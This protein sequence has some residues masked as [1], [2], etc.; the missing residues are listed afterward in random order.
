MAADRLRTYREKRDFTRTAEPS[1]S[2]RASTAA[3]R[4]YLIQKHAATRLHFDFRLEL[5][6]V[7]L[8]WAV[9]RGPSY[10]P[11]DKRLAVRTEDHPLEYGDFEGTIPKG[12]YGGGTVMLWDEG[13]WEPVGDPDAALDK[14]DF[15]FILHGERLKGKWVLVRMKPRPGERSKRENWLLI[16]ERDEYA[17][18]E[19]KP[20][21]ERAATSVRSGRTM[22]EIAEGNVEWLKTGRHVREGESKPAKKKGKPAKEDERPGFVEPQL[23]T[24]V[25]AAPLGDEWLHE[26]KYDGYRAL[27]AIGNKEAV[28]YTRRGLDWTD[29]FRPLARPLADLPCRSALVDGEVAITDAEGHTDFGALQDAM[30]D[31][32]RGIHY[33]L[34]DLLFLDGRD[35]RRLPLVER[36]EKLRELLADQPRAGPLFY[37]DHVTGHGD[38]FFQQASALGL[39]GIISKLADAPYRSGRSGTWLKSKTGMGQEFIIIGWRPSDV[40]GRPFSSLLLAVREGDHLRYAGRVGSG[41]GEPE[42]A[43]LWPELAKRRVKAPPVE[44]VPREIRRDA[45]FVK[46][47]L[48]AEIAYRG[49]TDDGIVRQASYKG[50][51]VDKKPAEVVVEIPKEVEDVAPTQSAGRRKPSAK[52]AKESSVIT[53]DKDD[54]HGTVTIQGVRITHPNRVLYPG[55]KVTKRSLVEYYVAVADRILPHVAG[56]PMSLVRCPEG[57]GGECFFQKHASPGFPDA[58][59]Q[60]QIR[61]KSGKQP[62]IYIEDAAGL[63][64]AVQMGVLELHIWGSHVGTLDQPDRIVF[65]F[66]PDEALQFDMVKDAAREMRERLD[67]LGLVSFVMASG[68][69]GLHVVV[70]LKPKHGWDD[71]KGFAEALART[72]A[73]ES[74]TRYLADMSKAKRKGRIFVDYLRNGRGATAIAPFST[75]A[76]KGAPVAWPLSWKALATLENAHPVSVGDA[77]AA[78]KRQRS[79]P[80]KG[81]F[82]V[83][84]VLPLEKLRGK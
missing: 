52:P 81:Y 76:R 26:I 49:I 55:E 31:G 48:V 50:L 41:F 8:S 28:I 66:D 33:Y 30:A 71:V 13:T 6:G 35:L 15:K 47:E 1:G 27:A 82:E 29:R 69:K 67:A 34:F 11:H 54:D 77:A 62:Y 53:I 24:L 19:K 38:E 20:V 46:P 63:A 9:T 83:D 36:K 39:E 74:P 4:R 32:G 17:E 43:R 73:A 10:D 72:L 25:D 78:L 16:K 80:W 59:K 70:P 64:A 56:R 75:R 5:H 40:A 60:I 51:R 65:D 23:A 44:E 12:E 21:I 58:L 42:L 7:L 18:E 61:D 3:G 2:G 84:Q 37:S 57:A 14:G 79:D 45:R 22:E 68:G